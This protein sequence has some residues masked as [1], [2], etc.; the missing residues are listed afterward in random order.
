ME[1]L[2]AAA[3]ILS[4]SYTTILTAG[5]SNKLLIKSVHLTNYTSSNAEITMQWVDSS[6]SN[7]AYFLAK[8]VVVP[9]ASSFQAIDGTLILNN[10]DS[11]KAQTSVSGSINATISYVEISNTEG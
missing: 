7:K 8:D 6:D 10:S 2:N 3:N 5:A 1:Y 11:L 4:G 9:N